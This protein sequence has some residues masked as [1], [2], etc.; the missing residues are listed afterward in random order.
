VSLFRITSPAA[1]ITVAFYVANLYGLELGLPQIVAGVLVASVV[2]IGLVGLPSQLTFFT[3]LGPIFLSMGIPLEI[4]PLLLAV[5]SL[6]DIWRTVGNVTG[7]V[8][9][10]TVIAEHGGAKGEAGVSGQPIPPPASS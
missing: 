7:H 1:N 4:L 9:A 10:S 5:E 8:A 2:S 6:P 3:S